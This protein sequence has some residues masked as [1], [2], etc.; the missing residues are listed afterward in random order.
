MA[1][2]GENN[3]VA[4]II[5]TYNSEG[6]LEY[7]VNSL[8]KN[9]SIDIYIVDNNSE[10]KEYLETF[11]K[12]EGFKIEFLEENIGFGRANNLAAR[13]CINNYEYLLFLN[14]DTFLTAH[15]IDL[16]LDFLDNSREK[17][18]IIS[19]PLF[20][21]DFNKKK[22]TN[23]IDSLGIKKYWWGKWVDYKMG[24]EVTSDILPTECYE[25]D[26]ICGALM[27]CKS[28]ALKEIILKEEMI[29]DEKLYMYKE[30]IDLSLRVKN[31]GWRLMINPKLK[32]YH[33]RGWEKD[34]KK[35]LSNS[36]LESA[37]NELIVN[38]KFNKTGVIYSFT[39]YIYVRFI[40]NKLHRIT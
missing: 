35:M 28:H 32:A 24:C 7:C 4:A 21:F 19:S 40:E 10:N 26:A 27:F 11:K 6:Y 33:C 22:P 25:P 20:G 38:W 12:N 23:K 3:R 30:D 5:V 34:R 17:I 8:K 9:D 14:P 2:K 18:G 39:K 29:F 31:A 37:K 15:W 16:T 36:R 1:S 13:N